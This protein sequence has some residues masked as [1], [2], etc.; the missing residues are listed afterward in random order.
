MRSVGRDPRTSPGAPESP[1][2]AAAVGK[3]TL[4]M[5]LPEAAPAIGPVQRQ[6]HGAPAAE[7]AVAE[8]A[9]A[10]VTG[11]GA[12]LP[13]LDII[14]RAFGR[15]DVRGVQAHGDDAAASAAR[16]I[17]ARAYAT[18]DHVAF[19][20]A[21]DLHTAAHEAAHVVQQRGGVQLKGSV[22]E[23]G[24]AHERHADVVAD[25]VVRGESAEPLLDRGAGGGGGGVQRVV[26]RRERESD[27]MRAHRQETEDYRRWTGDDRPDGAI[28]HG[29]AATRPALP[30][31]RAEARLVDFT[32]QARIA[33][34][35]LVPAEFVQRVLADRAQPQYADVLTLFDAIVTAAGTETFMLQMGTLERRAPELLH[36]VENHFIR[37]PGISG[38]DV[39]G[40][41]AAQYRDFH[42]AAGDY[43][44]GPAG[45]N[46][47]RAARMHS[48]MSAIRPER[49]ANSGSDA[50]ITRSQFNSSAHIRRF[51][52][53][54]LET[55]PPFSAAPAGSTTIPTQPPGKQLLQHAMAS[56]LRMRAA[57]LADG[58]ALAIT[59]GYRSTATAEANAAASGN[60]AAVASYSSHSLGLAMDLILS[61][62]NQHFAE[63]TT[64]PM[65]NVINMRTSPI[66]RWMLIRGAE[67]GWYPYTPEPWHW[68][69]NPP[70][71]RDQL[72]AEINP[73]TAA[74]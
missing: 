62:G 69:Y 29:D 15:Y 24:D 46:E 54:H 59:D 68:E 42:W 27:T 49:R 7:G 3:R 45:P 16:S 37:D 64:N 14:Q 48:A 63:T 41:D 74:P 9:A 32:L 57:A 72:M 70:G 22:G 39:L 60:P 31:S 71:F 53:E 19:A 34:G 17:G 52:T 13:H 35:S 11:A 40:A 38:L 65:Q 20:E 2:A 44:G 56:F 43:P 51:I 36:L 58:V 18:G 1:R 10:G 55:V 66:H 30:R 28:V 67:H 47:G 33:R 5:D 61:T 26:Q 25:A 4:S 50:V 8:T 12:T 6:A 23:A 73:P 21:P